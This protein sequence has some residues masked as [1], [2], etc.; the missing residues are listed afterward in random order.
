MGNGKQYGIKIFDGFYKIGV[1]GQ[2]MN[3][4]EYRLR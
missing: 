1:A 3:V 2:I 4:T